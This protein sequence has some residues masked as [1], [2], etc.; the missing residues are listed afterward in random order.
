MQDGP[1]RESAVAFPSTGLQQLRVALLDMERLQLRQWQPL[2][3]GQ[4]LR[5][6]R[7]TSR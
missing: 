4:T 1:S 6:Q 7:S 3:P 2:Q 5:R